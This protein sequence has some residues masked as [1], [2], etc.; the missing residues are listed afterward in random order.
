MTA[1]NGRLSARCVAGVRG[2]LFAAFYCTVL[3]SS[4]AASLSRRSCCY[5]NF[6]GGLACRFDD[7]IGDIA[8]LGGHRAVTHSVFFAL[9]VAAVI[10]LVTTRH[11]FES[12]RW[13]IGAYAAAVVLSHGLLDAFTTYGAGV[14][15]LAPVSPQ[16][17]KSPWHPFTDLTS[18]V[19][20]IWLPAVLMYLL[21][22][23]ARIAAR[24]RAQCSLTCA[25]AD[26]R[27][28]E[29]RSVRV[30]LTRSQLSWGVRPLLNELEGRSR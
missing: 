13:R 8:A 4:I 10:A 25:E 12:S 16:R 20:L 6:F 3:G 15:F 23:R 17:W 22:L 5:L 27:S 21:W 2:S 7:R 30:C 11:E 1:C 18:E 24:A 26:E 29:A 28:V 14:A 19:V 9:A